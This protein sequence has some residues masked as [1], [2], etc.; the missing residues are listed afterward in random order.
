MK[1]FGYGVFRFLGGRELK[2]PSVDQKTGKLDTA[3][4]RENLGKL[5]ICQV[6]LCEKMV[7]NDQDRRRSGQM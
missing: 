4:G 2:T 1:Y 3:C 5:R 7:Y 6:H